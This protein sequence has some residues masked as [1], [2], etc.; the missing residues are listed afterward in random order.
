[1]R[2]K[3]ARRSPVVRELI[4]RR[5]WGL[6]GFV[7]EKKGR[8][9]LELKGPGAD[10]WRTLTRPTRPDIYLNTLQT[11]VDYTRTGPGGERLLRRAGV[12]TQS[13]R[14]NL[15]D[16]IL[17]ATSAM[18][19]APEASPPWVRLRRGRVMKVFTPAGYALVTFHLRRNSVSGDPLVVFRLWS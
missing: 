18:L 2:T 13:C 9:E 1:M 6:G 12:C 3:P 4:K 7:V 10:L 5:M 15:G 14:T 19:L 8:V 16:L 11:L 17:C